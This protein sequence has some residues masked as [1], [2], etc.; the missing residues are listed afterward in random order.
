M[1]V[2]SV[3]GYSVEGSVVVVVV[4]VVVDYD[5]WSPTVEDCVSDNGSDRWAANHVVTVDI[6]AE[7]AVVEV[8]WIAVVVYWTN[9]RRDIHVVAKVVVI[10]VYVW[11]RLRSVIV[12]SCN[13]SR[14]WL[15]MSLCV[16]ASF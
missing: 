9:S 6:S 3:R 7:Q 8:V 11:Y 16:V 14:L 12:A 1:V 2:N 10:R 13:W 4:N 5:Y 15:S